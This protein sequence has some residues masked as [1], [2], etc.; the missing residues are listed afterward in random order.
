M[1]HKRLFTYFEGGSWYLNFVSR[2]GEKWDVKSFQQF[3]IYSIFSNLT[4]F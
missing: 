4:N 1:G 3:Y 2:T